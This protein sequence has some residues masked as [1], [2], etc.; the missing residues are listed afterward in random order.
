MEKQKLSKIERSWTLYDVACS[1]F[2]LILTAIIP[3]Y[4][5]SMGEG[6]G[7]TGTQTTSHWG[8]IQS[9]GTLV[10]ALL[11]PIL[12]S[13]ADY[14]GKK[15]MFFNFFFFLSILSLFAMV[16]FDNYY[17]LLGINLLA[18]I[19]YAGSNIFYDAF[20]VD[21]TD[22]SRMDYISSLGFGLGYIGSCVP[23]I[24]SILLITMEPFGLTGTSTI[25]ISFA[26]N[27]VWWLLF[28]IP[29]L[30]HVDQKYGKDEKPKHLI[31][32]SFRHVAATFKLIINDKT[33]G[34][35]LLAYFFYIDGVDT[36]IKMS[37]SFGADVG[38]DNTQMIFALLA[39]QVVAFPAVLICAKLA[40][41][42][43]TKMVLLISI[44]MYIG[45]CVFGY[46]LASAWQFWVLAIAVALVQGTIQA[47]SRSYFGRI[48]PNK[49]NSNEYFGFFNI[50]GRYATILGPLLMAGV[51]TVTGNTRDGVLS[52]ALLFIAGFVVF[53]FVPDIDKQKAE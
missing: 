43:S 2:S 5:K 26:I 3:L 39:T 1:A 34:L 11:A 30:R 44:A 27:A 32:Q 19:G 41:R 46:F 20:L 37:T 51:A 50:L 25:K 29:F 21:V 7:F 49:D 35:F 36:I 4:V 9:V 8:I 53:L 48:I 45:I 31:A 24:V 42:F 28:T 6:F 12:G 33:I 52:I 38:I 47:L 40:K 10:V 22:D 13:M 17:V 14:K 23:F 18:S 15:K 16:A